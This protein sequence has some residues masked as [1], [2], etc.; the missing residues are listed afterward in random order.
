MNQDKGK[1]YTPIIIGGVIATCVGCCLL[2]LAFITAFSICSDT[3]LAEILFP[4]A[5]YAD[6]TLDDRGLLALLLALVQYPTYGIVIGYVWMRRR[7]AVWTCV[8]I[9]FLAHVLAVGGAQY[10]VKAMWEYRFSHM[11]PR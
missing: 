6:P 9:L 11:Q 8:M 5:L 3:S 7:A 10:R 1:N 2:F 4:Y